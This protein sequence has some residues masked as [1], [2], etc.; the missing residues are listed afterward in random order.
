MHEILC[1]RTRKKK[2]IDTYVRVRTLNLKINKSTHLAR[3]VIDDG[4]LKVLQFLAGRGLHLE[5]NLKR[6]H[7]KR[8]DLGEG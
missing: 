4:L 8:G 5:R 7:Q 6:A 2:H 1:A 3:G